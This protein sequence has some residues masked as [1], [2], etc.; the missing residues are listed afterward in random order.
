M[1]Q[2]EDIASKHLARLRLSDDLQQWRVEQHAQGRVLPSKGHGLKPVS[3][4]VRKLWGVGKWPAALTTRGAMFGCANMNLFIGACDTR[5]LV[6]NYL[7]DLAFYYEHGYHK[8]FPIFEKLLKNSLKDPHAIQN[9]GGLERRIA[10]EIGPKYIKAKVELEEKYK[11][12]VGNRSAI[13]SRETAKLVSLC[14]SSLLGVAGEA[15][16][17]GYDPAVSWQT[18]CLAVQQL[19]SLMSA[20]TCTIA[21]S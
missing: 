16:A 1:E 19:M 6:C 17:C 5:T 8:V 13:M 7:D 11:T 2:P 12:M 20:A 18:W 21:R 9:P 4:E 14:E 3:D 15:A 10:A